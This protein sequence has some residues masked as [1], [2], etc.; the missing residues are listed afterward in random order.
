MIWN[1][2]ENLFF[3]SGKIQQQR[4]DWGRE[5]WVE[6]R[7]LPEICLLAQVWA[8]AHAEKIKIGKSRIDVTSAIF[9]QPPWPTESTMI[10]YRAEP[11]DKV[12]Y[13]ATSS[14]QKLWTFIWNPMIANLQKPIL[15]HNCNLLAGMILS[16]SIEKGWFRTKSWIVHHNNLLKNCLKVA[17]LGQSFSLCSQV[18]L[19]PIYTLRSWNDRFGYVS[20]ALNFNQ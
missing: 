11:T 8:I 15:L 3:F 7:E 20:L 10:T 17:L 1:Q 16:M 12:T 14:L 4:K 19:T 5:S 6:K 18:L 9:R 13:R 2:S